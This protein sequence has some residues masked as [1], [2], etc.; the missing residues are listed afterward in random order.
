MRNQGRPNADTSVFPL[1][2]ITIVQRAEN[3]VKGTTSVLQTKP[4][5]QI[6]NRH[7]YTRKQKSD[8]NTS[9]DDLDLLGDDEEFFTGSQADLEGAAENLFSYPPCPQP[10]VLHCKIRLK[11]GWKN[12]WAILLTSN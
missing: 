5:A 2:S 10:Q 11:I 7:R 4:H 6:K 3:L 12:P 8:V 9:K 1:I